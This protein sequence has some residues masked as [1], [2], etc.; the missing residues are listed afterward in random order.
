MLLDFGFNVLDWQDKFYE[1]NDAFL[2]AASLI[3]CDDD[4]SVHALWLL[5][6]NQKLYREPWNSNHGADVVADVNK[7]LC[8]LSLLVSWWTWLGAS[9]CFVRPLERWRLLMRAW[10]DFDVLYR[11]VPVAGYWIPVF[12][13]FFITTDVTNASTQDTCQCLRCTRYYYW[14]YLNA[15]PKYDVDS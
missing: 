4:D 13:H 11:R 6:E 3:Q 5:L 12:S 9:T 8:F 2:K 10:V 7:P 1:I 14:A 15:L